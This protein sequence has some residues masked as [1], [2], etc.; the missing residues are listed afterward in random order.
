LDPIA[1]SPG[2]SEYALRSSLQDRRFNPI[3]ADEV[4]SLS[5]KLSILHTFEPC[6]QAY[7]WQ[8]G[9]HGILIKF[10]DYEGNWYSATYLPEVAREHG[11]THEVAIR[12]LVAKAGY[13]GPCD[14]ELITRMQVQRYQST[15]ESITHEEY[16][17]AT[18]EAY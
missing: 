7:D 5:C 16:L 15:A 10:Q 2:L 9:T 6:S 12:E 3:S 11:M 17:A 4:P 1:V 8:V 14:R 18:V 13:H